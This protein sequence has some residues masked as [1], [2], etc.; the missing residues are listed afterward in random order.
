MNTTNQLFSNDGIDFSSTAQ[1]QVVSLEDF[2][3]DEDLPKSEDEQLPTPTPQEEL[4][5]VLEPIIETP[6][7]SEDGIDYSSKGK[8]VASNIN[9]DDIIAPTAIDY[10]SVLTKLMSDKVISGIDAVETEDGEIA[11]NDLEVD[12]DT[13]Y[14]IIHQKIKEDKESSLAGT[15]KADGVSEFTRKLIEI[16]KSGGDIN[17][18]LASYAKYQAPLENLD[19]VNSEQDQITV[20]Y[21]KYSAKGLDDAD[22]ARMIKGFKSDGLLEEKASEALIDLQR[23]F[24]KHMDSI[25]E[26]AEQQKLVYAEE[27]KNYR[28]SLKDQL[29]AFEL[30][31]NFKKKLLDSATKENSQGRFDLDDT[32]FTLRNNP[33]TA[34][35]L[36][37]FLTDK[38]EYIK[39]VTKNVSREANL[40]AMKKLKLV[41]RGN[42]ALDFDSSDNKKTG[43][44]DLK[45]LL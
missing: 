7:E 45:H 17:Q 23:A 31:D 38:N 30:N 10:K 43:Y 13:F 27:L 36:I 35:E 33:A 34:A 20:I 9:S 3:S 8:E 18:A 29:N 15:I 28:N 37:L 1:A 42:S 41:K 6:D 4:D 21:T 44:T 24:S 40:S 16:E 22:I 11:F 19:I 39:Q 32:Y 12:E 2:L 26:Q 25:K 5:K 14:N